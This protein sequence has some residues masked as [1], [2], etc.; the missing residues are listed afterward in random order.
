MV[1][2]DRF[3]GLFGVLGG[4][5]APAGSL[6]FLSSTVMPEQMGHGPMR[7]GQ[8]TDTPE[9][10]FFGKSTSG[11]ISGA[12]CATASWATGSRSYCTMNL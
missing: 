12:V 11:A 7:P 8:E 10:F 5:L 1:F 6:G 2:G 3:R 9:A 4:D